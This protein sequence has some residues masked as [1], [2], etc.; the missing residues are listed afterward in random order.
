[1]VLSGCVSPIA[2]HH[3]VLAYD[4]SVERVT[5]EQLLLNIIRAGFYQPL[6]FTKVSS[7]AAT[8][9]FRVS[10]GITPPEEDA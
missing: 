2:L 6:H 5:G 4:R 9:D 1:M 3:A 8:F 10:A 7:I